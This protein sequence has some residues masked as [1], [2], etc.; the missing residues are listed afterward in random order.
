MLLKEQSSS[1]LSSLGLRFRLLGIL[2]ENGCCVMWTSSQFANLRSTSRMSLSN[3][4][5]MRNSGGSV[6]YPFA[7]R[8]IQNTKTQDQNSRKSSECAPTGHYHQNL[9]YSI[10]YRGRVPIRIYQTHRQY[11]VII[12]HYIF[13]VLSPRDQLFLLFE[14]YQPLHSR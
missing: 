14:T 6:Q 12:H 8:R 10:I 1:S 3:H 5:S 7:V 4:E 11:I 13:T 9:L 2:E